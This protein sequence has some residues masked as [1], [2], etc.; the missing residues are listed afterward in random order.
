MFRASRLAWPGR[1]GRTVEAVGAGDEH[2]AFAKR[3]AMR[4]AVERHQHARLPIGR[5]E[6]VD[7]PG[8]RT[9]EEVSAGFEGDQ[10][11]SP[12]IVAQELDLIP[13]RHCDGEIGAHHPHAR[14]PVLDSRH[15]RRQ[16]RREEGE[17]HHCERG[18][19]HRAPTEGTQ[20]PPRSTPRP[21]LGH[22][23][24]ELGRMRVRGDELKHDCA[25]VRGK[26][27]D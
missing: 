6:A 15:L 1:Q 14:N 10:T 3:D 2:L 24:G 18:N 11:R 16:L 12:E 26:P 4:I 20:T 17:T 9:R 5:L 21:V 8:A 13:A 27:E 25:N 23:H 7:V 22:R 19:E